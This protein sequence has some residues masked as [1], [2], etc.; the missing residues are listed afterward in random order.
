MDILQLDPEGVLRI[1]NV[2]K[3]FFPEQ[4]NSWREIIKL[5]I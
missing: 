1:C 2:I 3:D 5:L 4:E